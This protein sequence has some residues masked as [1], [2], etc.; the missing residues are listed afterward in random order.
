MTNTNTHPLNV[1]IEDNIA[2]ITGIRDDIKVFIYKLNGELAFMKKY[3]FA[4]PKLD[5]KLIDDIQLLKG[6]YTLVIKT[7][8]IENVK[9]VFKIK[10]N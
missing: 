10:K 9:T 4:S 5:I 6:K 1:T 2:H 7:E 3:K 8:E